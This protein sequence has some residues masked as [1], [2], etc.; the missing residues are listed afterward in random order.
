[1]PQLRCAALFAGIGGIELGLQKA[2]HRTEL[3]CE[4]DEHANAVLDAQFPGVARVTDVSDLANGDAALPSEVN[5]ISAGFPC[6]D[7]SQ[8]G[9]T[10]GLSGAKSS[11]IGE[12]FRLLDKHPVPWLLLEN[13]PFML[14]LAQGQAMRVI[15]AELEGRGYDWA[16]RV[17]DTQCFGLPQRRARVFL[18]ASKETHPAKVLFQDDKG[19]PDAKNPKDGTGRRPCGF[20]WT[21]GLRGLGWAVDA[22][23]TLKGGSTIGIPS[24]PAV[25]MPDGEIVTPG[26]R[27][28][29]RLQGLSPDWTE[30]A[31]RVG[32]A[33]F[34]WKLVGNAVTVHAAKWVGE[35]LASRPAN[36]PPTS[37]PLLESGALP[38]AGFGLDGKRFRVEVSRWP[39][40]KPRRSLKKY[41]ED[42][43]PLSERATRGFA[44]RLRRSSLRGYPDEFLRDLDKHAE[45]MAK[46]TAT[47]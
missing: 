29:E 21:E 6:Q 7:L 46:I 13:V 20:Y 39:E 34:R 3:I 14:Q 30:A 17:V 47:T 37:D 40:R 5:L 35:C 25:W 19:E 41:L 44:S 31:S 10:Q 33:S 12:V 28:A 32:K 45:R 36:L 11:L 38:D 26:I 43:K 2:G 4:K 22:I 9:R 27:D 15:L 18:L 8:A 23:P 24:P 16:Y 42:K 1:M